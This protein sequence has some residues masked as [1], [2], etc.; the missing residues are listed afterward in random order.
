VAV[1]FGAVEFDV[2]IVTPGGSDA[3]EYTEVH[4]PGGSVNYLDIGGHLPNRLELR[5]YFGDT[6]YNA[7]RALVGTQALLTYP[8]GTTYAN[9]FLASLRRVDRKSSTYTIAEAVFVT[10]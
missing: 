7:L 10:P 5:L 1:G 3:A 8:T 6:E 4:I 2:L 9:A